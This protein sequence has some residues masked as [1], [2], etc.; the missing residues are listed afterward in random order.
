MIHYSDSEVA[1]FH[2]ICENAL[3]QAISTLGL[4][5]T[6]RIVHHR[7]TGSLE[8]DYVIEN[9]TTGKYLC[10]IEVKRKPAD[11]NSTRYQIQ[12][13]SYVQSNTGMNERAFYIL[14]NLEYAYAF[15]YDAAKPRPFQQMLLP[16]L[17]HIA[18]FSI[19]DESAVTNKLALYFQGYI[20]DFIS[21]VYTYMLTLESF[22]ANMESLKTMPREWK[23]HLAIYFYEFIRG[24]F[25]YIHR[26]DLRDVRVFGH[27]VLKICTE[28]SR[29]NFK[30]IYDYSVASFTPTVSVANTDLVN[31]YELGKQNI[32]GDSIA[33]VLHSI[34]SAGHEHDGEVATDLELGQVLAILAKDEIGTLEQNDIVCDPAA[35]SGNLIS[36]A[37]DSMSLQP[38]QIL[39][40]D[41]NA[42]LIE[43]LTLRIGLNFAK[44]ISRINSPTVSCK[45]I[46]N[47]APSFFNGV[48]LLLLNP[49]YVA[50]IN[51]NAP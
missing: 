34:V 28:A 16:G 49:P 8:M 27:D 41:I 1:V 11:V 51:V 42:K 4:D 37:I 47:L 22:A 48:K 3:N 5:G 7:Y 14:T 2:P 33:N 18:D 40:N 38:T 32:T 39:A 10:V 12:A 6:Y 23:S 26:S 46:C 21:D 19:D 31:L 13:M 43:L 35:G 29:V 25:N 24:S 44:V 9:I 15:R 50:G 20:N 45:D 17:N 30:G 36:A